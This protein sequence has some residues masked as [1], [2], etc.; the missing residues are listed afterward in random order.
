MGETECRSWRNLPV[1]GASA[2]LKR[3]MVTSET[4]VFVVDDDPSFRRS[5]EMLIESAGLSVQA[6]GRRRGRDCRRLGHRMEAAHL[7]LGRRGVAGEHHWQ[8]AA[9]PWLFRRGLP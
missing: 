7:C 8:S 1:H 9:D 4:I 6:F 2:D 5:T 3:N